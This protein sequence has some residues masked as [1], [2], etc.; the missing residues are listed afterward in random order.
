VKSPQLDILDFAFTPPNKPRMQLKAPASLK[1][2]RVYVMTGESGA[3]KSTLARILLGLPS[4]GGADLLAT[5]HAMVRD[6]AGGGAESAGGRAVTLRDDNGQGVAAREVCGFIPQLGN[7]GFIGDLSVTAN[8]TLFSGLAPQDAEIEAN[9]A[10]VQLGFLTLPKQIGSASGGEQVRLAAARALMPRSR[11][12][13]H[14]AVLIA[15]EPTTGLDDRS[16]ARMVA[17]LRDVAR[18][19]ETV[20]I[21]ITHDLAAWAENPPG[22][23][24][25]GPGN[26]AIYECEAIDGRHHI[27][28]DVAR[29]IPLEA[30]GDRAPMVARVKSAAKGRALAFLDVLGGLALS[31]VA[32]VTGLAGVRRRV[33]RP[34]VADVCRVALNPGTLVFAVVTS[35]IIAVT[36]GIFIFRQM[37]QRELLEPL[38]LP[39]TLMG[40]GISLVLFLV[41]M[42]TALFVVAKNSAAQ[43]ARLAAGVRG[44]LTDTLMLARIPSETYALVPAAI[45]QMISLAIATAAGCVAGLVACALVFTGGGAQLSLPDAVSVMFSGVHTFESWQAWLAAKVL[46]SGFVGGAVA[47]CMGL[48]PAA[49]EADVGRAV[50]RSLVWSMFGVFAVQCALIV[51]QMNGHSWT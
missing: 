5:G 4:K 36:M 42:F 35:A 41:P 39:D 8:V 50:H 37:P 23:E 27:T 43:A 11:G 30:R 34:I 1:A 15:D 29:F 6:V 13:K 51:A 7:L 33:V 18:A 38:L 47:A 16:A 3:G 44:G 28:R 17:A 26:I 31:P 24:K 20:V 22:P 21:V 46:L 9:K 19:G 2:G 12:E 40:A 48:R 10:G 49:S 45:S 32:F 14:P 25:T